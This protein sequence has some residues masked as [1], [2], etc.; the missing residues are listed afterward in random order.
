MISSIDLPLAVAISLIRS[1]ALG[2]KF[3]Q[4]PTSGVVERCVCTPRALA[5]TPDE[6]G[7]AIIVLH[8]TWIETS[9]VYTALQFEH[10]RTSDITTFRHRPTR[11]SRSLPA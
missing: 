10:T 3:I 2:A 8:T 11:R 4:I 6:V 7:S 5:T 1:Q 9:C